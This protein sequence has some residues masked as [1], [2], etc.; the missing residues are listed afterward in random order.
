MVVLPCTEHIWDSPTVQDKRP[1]GLESAIY[2]EKGIETVPIG[3]GSRY[4]H[5]TSEHL[6]VENM[7]KAVQILQ[8]I[9]ADEFLSK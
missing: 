2:S 1:S 5:S 7:K 6:S 9:L 3:K 4:A 8:Y